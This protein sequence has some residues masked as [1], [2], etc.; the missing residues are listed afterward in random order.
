M[1]VPNTNTFT[2]E[3]VCQQNAFLGRNPNSLVGARNIALES[4]G[5]YP[6]AFRFDR[7][8][9]VGAINR[10]SQFRSWGAAGFETDFYVF[11]SHLT[12]FDVPWQRFLLKSGATV[13]FF[14]EDDG[15]G[16]AWF[17]LNKSTDAATSGTVR[18]TMQNNN[19]GTA[20]T[21]AMGVRVIYPTGVTYWE[22]IVRF[23]QPSL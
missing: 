22:N 23:N 18:V 2:L 4:S 19:T 16:T 8:Y 17:F 11:G 1:A 7:R 10:L 20:R 6:F 9:A 14:E 21:G 13:S 3:D 5:T 15:S 12:F